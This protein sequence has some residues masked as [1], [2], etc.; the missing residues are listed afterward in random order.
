MAI[1][2]RIRDYLDSHNVGCEEIPHSQAFE[3]REVAQA[4]HVPETQF[5]KVVVLRADVRLLM[6]VLP[7]SHRIDFHH[8]REKLGVSHLEM[9]GESELAALCSDCELGAFPPFGG[10][11]GMEVLIDGGMTQSQEIIFN[12]GTH[13]EAVRMRYADYAR[14]EKPQVA[15]FAELPEC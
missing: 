6:A 11:Y 10:L 2:K 3:A 13:A 9:A 8:L 14:L 15:R 4:L 1:S 7:A 5:A 12:A